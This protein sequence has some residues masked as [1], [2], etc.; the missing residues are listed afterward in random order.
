[1]GTRSGALDPGVM[2]YLMDELHMD[3]RAIEKLVYM[4]SGLLGVSVCVERHA[5]ALGEF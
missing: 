1:M 3:A 2:L 5:Y 4:E